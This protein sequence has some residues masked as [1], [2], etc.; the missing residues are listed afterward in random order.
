MMKDFSIFTDEELREELRRRAVERRKNT[1]REIVYV[2]FEGTITHVDNIKERHIDGTVR[3]K[4]FV[5]WRYRISDCTSELANHRIT[6]FYYLQ[7]GAFKRST[8]PNL[9]DRVKLR[10]RRT[11]R[12]YEV[13]DLSKAKI[14]EIIKR[15]E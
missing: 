2:E 1:P 10:Y 7:Q 13:F 9:G 6:D 12:Q 8:T 14:I 4:P 5:F 11:K 15:K 3:Y